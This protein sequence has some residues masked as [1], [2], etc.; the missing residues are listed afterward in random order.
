[1]NDNPHG[2]GHLDATVFQYRG[3]GEQV[4][5]YVYSEDEDIETE[6]KTYTLLTATNNF[7]VDTDTG[8]ISI[9]D[10][11]M[12][13]MYH[14]KV[15]VADGVHS[16]QESTVNVT[17]KYVFESDIY[18]STSMRLSG[19]SAADFIGKS[20]GQSS[21]QKFIKSLASVMGVDENLVDV[22]AVDDVELDAG[23]MCIMSAADMADVRY[24]VQGY[25]ATVLDAAVA[26]NKDKIETD[27]GIT[28]SKV[29]V[30]PC[31]DSSVCGGGSCSVVY[32][33]D[34]SDETLQD[35]GPNSL[36]LSIKTSMTAECTCKA[37]TCPAPS[38]DPNPCYNGGICQ[39]TSM[40]YQCQ[41]PKGYL[42]PRCQDTKRS[43][44][45]SGFAWYDS[46]K[47]CEDSHTSL[48]FITKSADGMLLYNGPTTDDYFALKDYIAIGMVDGKVKLSIN[49]GNGTLHLH[50]PESPR[51]DDRKWH[52]VDVY[53]H[54]L[55]VYLMIDGCM[56]SSVHEYPTYSNEDTSTCLSSGTVP[57]HDQILNLN[58]ALQLGGTDS[59]YSYPTDISFDVSRG[60][61]GCIRH[62]SQDGELLHL[63]NPAKEK[64]SDG[65][66]SDIYYRC[67]DEESEPVC[68]HGECVADMASHYCVCDAGYYGA[69]C[70]MET[71]EY[72]FKDDSYVTY[73]LDEE[74]TDI[75]DPKKTMYQISFR[76]AN[77][78]GTILST[79]AD[80]TREG[81]EYIR[82]RLVDGIVT[83]EYD[84]GEGDMTMQ[85]PDVL[86][87]DS[88]W[89]SVKLM[90]SRNHFTLKVDKGVGCQQVESAAGTFREYLENKQSLIVGAMPDKSDD[91]IGCM[92]D[93]RIGMASIYSFDGDTG[94]TTATPSDGVE[95]GCSSACMSNPCNAT[96]EHSECVDKIDGYI[97]R[98]KDG[99][100]DESDVCELIDE[101]DKDNQ[102]LNGGTC[103][104]QVGSFKCD[105]T[106][107]YM[108]DICQFKRVCH[109]DN[110]CKNGSTCMDREPNDYRCTC[111]HGWMG[112]TCEEVN[113]CE[114][115]DNPCHN[116]GDCESTGDNEYICH[117]AY[118][119]KGDNCEID[120][121][122]EPNRCRN[123]GECIPSSGSY[124]CNCPAGYNGDRCETYD[125][126]HTNP[127]MNGGRCEVKQGGFRCDCKTGWK[128]TVCSESDPCGSE[129]CENGGTC[130]PTANND[131]F[132]CSC[133]ED[134]GGLTCAVS[135]GKDDSR[136]AG[137]IAAGVLLGVAG[138]L[139]LILLVHCCRNQ[140]QPKKTASDY[141]EM[142]ASS[143]STS[144]YTKRST[145][146][147]DG[148]NGDIA[149][150]SS[151]N[152]YSTVPNEENGIDNTAFTTAD[153]IDDKKTTL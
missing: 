23:T 94:G 2:P 120:D 1:M 151:G 50:V 126:C 129:P 52:K 103:V 17:V 84:I 41:C 87:N 65:K 93:L 153:E 130:I 144:V 32:S 140:Q 49:F 39:V 61:D 19:L 16:D 104:D 149:P 70:S 128:G 64:D 88:M 60:F 46:L 145:A 152:V 132:M 96:D 43:F 38:C 36:S 91:F 11:T 27:A 48:E 110:P 42:G 118:G 139:A 138:L 24:S 113:A 117:C 97:C 105:C 63:G 67:M 8:A 66:C 143:V 123:G 81:Q 30:N 73:T 142:D 20:G 75:Q 90:R 4:I 7:A 44:S 47:T 28:I 82:I 22:L 136:T 92:K 146:L 6:S 21:L 31:E 135:L 112:S 80:A 99:Y 51:L 89:H 124:T 141:T 68:Q 95:E 76:T 85:V 45:G 86:V 148:D 33:M 3:R 121:P 10:K 57:G 106:P 125:Y 13:G 53:K 101:C 147:M 102:C 74:D 71:P 12:Q 55:Q 114:Q 15:N 107:E 29:K 18:H 9:M 137:L 79:T 35:S 56:T 26:K 14:F 5:G 108:G 115:D 58:S 69:D 116:G 72:R 34:T 37:K 119:Y 122:C 133:G 83:L 150:H 25:H 109:W 54:G 127:C 98:C 77:P 78:S 40:G 134:W 111:G 59:S 131:G 62:L 100:S